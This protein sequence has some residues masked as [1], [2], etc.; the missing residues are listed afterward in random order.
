MCGITG[1]FDTQGQREP[2]R[3][4]LRRMNQVQLH[5][6]PDEGG[7]H[8][9][10]GLALGHRRLSII[11]LSTGQQ[12]LANEDGSVLVVF[13]GEIYNFSS[14]VPELQAKGHVFRTHSDTEV[15]VHAWEEWGAD[16][17]LRF[18]GMFA[19][20]LWDRNRQ[21]FFLAR[22]RLGKKPLYYTLTADHRLLFASELKSLLEE[23]SLPRR[24]DR[25]AVE[26]YL[27]LGYVPDPRS[28]LEGVNKL[29]PGHTLLWRRG[30]AVPTTHK[31]W[32]VAF[33]PGAV[34]T[35]AEV[36]EEVTARL[37]EATRVRLMS[38]VPLGAFLSGGV[39][40]SAVVAMMA[41]LST[42][43]VKTCS[44]SFGVKEYDESE[45]AQR[46]ASQFGTDHFVR[47][48]DTDDFGLLDT[49]AQV[50]D[51]PFADSSAIPTYRV[52]QLARTR[53]TVALS[54]DGG[55][56]AFAGYRR[57]KWFMT[58]QRVR[59]LL[60][61]AIRRPVFGALGRWYPKLDRAPKIFRAKATLEAIARD[62]VDGY[63][64]GVSVAPDRVRLPLYSRDF[65]AALE[66]HRA[67]DV[68]REHARH[69]PTRDPLSLVQYLDFKTYLPG[70]ILVKVDRASMAHSLEVRAPLLD[71]T[72]IDWVSGL[73][74]GMKLRGTQG[75]YIFKKSL[76]P[77]L[78]HD[79][80][81]RPKMG[82]GVPLAE[83]L[84]GPLRERVRERLLGPRADQGGIFEPGS[85]RNLVAQHETGARDHSAVI[86]ALLMLDAS[87]VH[88][89][90]S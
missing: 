82:F 86:W 34:R 36:A 61:D 78:P 76:E 81:Y 84:R 5:R 8:F 41:G 21:S 57:Y 18:N 54:G 80:L 31:Y 46:V 63:F 60:P 87:R 13:N 68:M 7:E 4:L 64:H 55:D 33:V 90:A 53:V 12:P 66:G 43:P 58:E 75:K 72:Y 50:Y 25:R 73:S 3:D 20:A 85:I 48:V 6:G 2:D 79:I 1:I 77:I 32:D 88:L 62:A 65:L 71:Y 15:I 59:Q 35:E 26:E 39:D 27:G 10:P 67:V 19:F 28:I 16:C 23:P 30:G 14:L 37:R 83:W 11:D 74:P 24:L 89:R 69:S 47:R 49:L 17:V 52:C 42:E 29:A 22:D 70:D 40:S 51:E 56:E 38:E 45:Y 44:I 9:E